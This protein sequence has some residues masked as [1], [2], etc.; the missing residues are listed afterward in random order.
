MF[1]NRYQK[2]SK[3]ELISIVL[4]PCDYQDEAVLTAKKIIEEKSWTADLKQQIT[5]RNQKRTEEEELETIE[6]AEKAAY[7]QNILELKKEKNSFE[8]RIADVAGF[9]ARLVENEIEFYRQDKNI[10]A[11]LDL[12][13]TQ[14]YFFKTEDCARVDELVIEMG[15]NTV[16]YTNPFI[17]MQFLS[18]IIGVLVAFIIIFEVVIYS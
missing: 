11:Q 15:M 16:P 18:I 6:M 12:Y 8:V 17:S 4:N 9:E 1:Y 7:Y 13:P 10:G 2:L 5:E 3:E 14:T